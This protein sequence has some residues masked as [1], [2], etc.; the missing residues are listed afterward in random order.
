MQKREFWKKFYSFE[1]MLTPSIIKFVF[2]LFVAILVVSGL[3]TIM[4]SFGGTYHTEFGVM[5]AAGSFWSFVFGILKIVLGIIFAKIFC[6]MIIVIFK[7]NE[8]L[9]AIRE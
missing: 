4:H 1:E 9:S 7:I 8:N 2:W 6:E 3:V 5:H